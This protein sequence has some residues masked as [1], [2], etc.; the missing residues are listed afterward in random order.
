M[1]VEPLINCVSQKL[2]VNLS[3]LTNRQK[4]CIRLPKWVF[5]KVD[6]RLKVTSFGDPQHQETT[7]LQVTIK[8]TK[9]CIFWFWKENQRNKIE[10]PNPNRGMIQWAMKYS[11]KRKTRYSLLLASSVVFYV[12]RAPPGEVVAGVMRYLFL[13]RFLNFLSPLPKKV[14]SSHW[15]NPVKKDKTS[16]QHFFSMA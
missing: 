12:V 10:V 1:S 13:L 16:T 7:L 15:K 9:K 5:V 8:M 4:F 3:V 11:L 6:N 14:Q 2:S